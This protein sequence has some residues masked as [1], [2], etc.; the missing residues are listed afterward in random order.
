MRSRIELFRRGFL[1]VLA[2]FVLASSVAVAEP[3]ELEVSGT[4]WLKNRRLARALQRLQV[5]PDASTLSAN[6]VEDAVFFLYSALRDE[7]HLRPV[8]TLELTREDGTMFTHEFDPELTSLLPRPLSVTRVHFKVDPGVKYRFAEVTVESNESPL[9]DEEIESLLVPGDRAYSPGALRSGES[10]VVQALEQQG[11]AQAEVRASETSANDENGDVAVAVTVQPGPQWWVESARIE[12]ERPEAVEWPDLDPL[13]ERPWNVMWEQDAMEAVRHAYFEQGYPDVR[14]RAT[15]ALGD[16]TAERQPVRVLLTV[17]PGERVTVG[18]VRFE[19]E[20]EVRP[21]VLRRRVSME[22][23]DPLNPVQIEAARYRLGRLGAFRNVRLHYEPDEGPV[24]SPVFTLTELPQWEV[25]LLAGYGSYEQLRGGLEVRRNNL[26]GRAHQTRLELVQSF[27]SSRGEMTY[28]VPELFGETVDGSVQ[29]FGLSRDEV[30]FIREE[31]GGTVSLRRRRLPWI[32]AE[33]TISYTYQQLRNRE[34]ELTTRDIDTAKTIAASIDLGLTRD[35][36]DNP[37]QPR[38]GYRWFTQ[39]EIADERFGGEVDYQRF[40]LGYSYH[41]PWGSRRWIHAALTH[42][43]VLTLGSP[44]DTELPVN[45]RFFPGG[46]SSIRG[47][48]LGEAAPRGPDGRFLGAKSTLLLNLELE[49]AIVGRWTAV[50]FFDS[51]AMASRLSEYPFEQYLHTLG[52]GVRYNTI[53]GPLRIEYGHNLNPREDDPSGT[54]HF[55]L[56]FPF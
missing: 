25:H 33:G 26:W 4:G 34:N 8:L 1:L 18:E 51:L 50:L 43:V 5:N 52:L 41:R 37:L 35:R 2:G 32:H 19:G 22:E 49:Q 47:F 39:A 27:K 23:G 11:Y 30:A 28:T 53:I 16:L 13:V 46:D 3:V 20:H 31:F 45:R 12:G 44:N 29:L 14:V 42:G 21:K 40:E 24:R 9:D 17:T 15:R 48:Q 38:R 10:R 36:R 56:G 7:G 6:G 54:L 55:S